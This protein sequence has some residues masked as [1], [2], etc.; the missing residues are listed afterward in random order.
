LKTSLSSKIDI[1]K[2]KTEDLSESTGILKCGTVIKVSREITFP[3]A[4]DY[5]K[6]LDDV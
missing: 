1:S 2:K 6:T 4:I 5:A 3:K